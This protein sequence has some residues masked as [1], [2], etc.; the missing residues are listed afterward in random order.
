MHSIFNTMEYV[1]WNRNLENIHAS[2]KQD[3]EMSEPEI[4][5]DAFICMFALSL[6]FDGDLGAY[7][8]PDNYRLKGQGTRNE[9]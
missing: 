1:K 7:I 6:T 4:A 3:N 5:F 8:L 2:C 9:T